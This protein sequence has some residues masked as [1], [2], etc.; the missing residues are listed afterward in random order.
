MLLSRIGIVERRGRLQL[1]RFALSEPQ[2]GKVAGRDHVATENVDHAQLPG[3]DL[4]PR[5]AARLTEQA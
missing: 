3:L 4:L 2:A 1:R 5:L